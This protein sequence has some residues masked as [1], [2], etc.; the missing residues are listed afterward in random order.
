[1]RDPAEIRLQNLGLISHNYEAELTG[2]QLALQYLHQENICHRKI[3]VVCDCVPAIEATFSYKNAIDYNHVIMYNRNLLHHLKTIQQDKIDVVWAPS[4]TGIQI[5]EMADMTAKEEAS[6]RIKV[7]RP[8]ERK[9]VLTHAKEQVQVNWQRRVDHELSN[10]QIMEINKYVGSWKI[11]NFNS[12]K[13]LIR[14][15]TG[16]HFLNSFQSKLNHSVS[17]KCSCGQV[18]TMNHYLFLCQKYMRY[19]LKWQH[20]V[21][22]ITEDLMA[23]NHISLT[24][25]FGQRSDLSKE[26][27]R[28][29]QESLCNYIEETKRFT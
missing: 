7:K 12:S 22:G 13:H 2:L 3:L 19:R 27:N 28:L 16:H 10:H 1:M 26:K 11:H 25:A 5:N 29:L 8:L 18:E 15:V 17:R 21:V 14:L 20:K 6:K 4:H 23:L 9:I 24:T